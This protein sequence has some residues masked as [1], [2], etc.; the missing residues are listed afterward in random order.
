MVYFWTFVLLQLADAVTTLF[1]LRHGASEGN[2]VVA[3]WFGLVGP[4]AGLL[5]VKAIAILAALLVYLRGHRRVYR[6][7]SILFSGVVAWNCYTLVRM[8]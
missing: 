2:V 3:F 1:G 6:D 4:W 8:F 7:L 5:I